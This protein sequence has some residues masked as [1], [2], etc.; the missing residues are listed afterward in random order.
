[1]LDTIAPRQALKIEVADDPAF[2]ALAHERMRATRKSLFWH[3][4]CGPFGQHHARFALAKWMPSGLVTKPEM[5]DTGLHVASKAARCFCAEA[6]ESKA[7]E[8]GWTEAHVICFDLAEEEALED[9]GVLGRAKTQAKTFLTTD[10]TQQ[11]LAD[12]QVTLAKQKEQAPGQ[13]DQLLE[14]IGEPPS[15]NKPVE[16]AFWI[17]A[18]VNPLPGMGVCWSHAD[19]GKGSHLQGRG[20]RTVRRKSI[21]IPHDPIP[22][23]LGAVF[24]S[25]DA[26]RV[27]F[28]NTKK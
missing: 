17:G 23:M 24:D 25:R 28:L 8:G 18:L 5:A 13:I 21:R 3:D 16:L 20:C 10:R 6:G 4:C 14:D 7:A 26:S 11:T 9:K 19:R 2:S 27:G 22:M 15:A 12:Q 1:M